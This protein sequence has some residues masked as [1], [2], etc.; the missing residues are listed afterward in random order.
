MPIFNPSCLVRR[1]GTLGTKFRLLAEFPL[2]EMQLFLPLIYVCGTLVW[3][4]FSVFLPCFLYCEKPFG[5]LAY[6]T[7]SLYGKDSLDGKR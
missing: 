4:E 7:V 5:R 2:F 1:R 3:I 6:L